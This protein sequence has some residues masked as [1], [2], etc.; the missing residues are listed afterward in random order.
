M[1]IAKGISCRASNGRQRGRPWPIYPRAK[2][3]GT[4]HGALRTILA[5]RESFFRAHD[6]A[7]LDRP[8]VRSFARS[9]HKGRR[10][11]NA[12][13]PRRRTRG[14]FDA[15]A[16]T[17]ARKKE[18]GKYRQGGRKK[19][20]GE[21]RNADRECERGLEESEKHAD[22]IYDFPFSSLRLSV[23]DRRAAPR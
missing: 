20:E 6:R 4:R 7:G 17:S 8:S 12:G 13:I 16:N 21:R 14:V 3:P 11:S 15:T 1:R 10:L 23:A 2:H 5:F 22:A 18:R 19:G 9:T